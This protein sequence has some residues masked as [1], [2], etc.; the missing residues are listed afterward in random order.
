MQTTRPEEAGRRR[1]GAWTAAAESDKTGT[2]AATSGTPARLAWRG[3]R[4]ARGRA[5]GGVGWPRGGRIRRGGAA[6]DG[7]VRGENDGIRVRVLWRESRGK[8]RGEAEATAAS[9]VHAGGG[10]RHGAGEDDTATAAAVLPLS[11]TGKRERR[12]IFAKTPSQHLN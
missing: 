3:G 5:G 6:A 7:G 11:R 10:A 4:G 8:R 9:L 1:D 2:A 12:R